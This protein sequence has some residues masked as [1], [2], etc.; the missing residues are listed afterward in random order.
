[1]ADV[2]KSDGLVLYVSD[3]T[4]LYPFACAKNSSVSI[5]KDMLEL[6]PKT[7]SV[8]RE[9]ISGRQTYTISGSGLIKISQTGMHP[10]SFFDDFI[11]G[12]DTIYTGRLD[13]IDPQGNYLKYSFSCYIQQLTVESTYGT[14]PSYSYTLQGVGPLVA[15]P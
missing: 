14:T 6:A 10:L 4:N 3:G 12:T 2:L 8:F 15:I 7:N 13:M 5:S 11:T 1:M 9:Y